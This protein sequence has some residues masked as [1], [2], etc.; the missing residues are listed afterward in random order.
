[1]TKNQK[2][3]VDVIIDSIDKDCFDNILGYDYVKEEMVRWLKFI[4]Y[5]ESG[6]EWTEGFKTDIAFVGPEGTGKGLMAESFAAIYMD[7][8]RLSYPEGKG[9]F[10]LQYR[11][12]KSMSESEIRDGITRMAYQL[13]EKKGECDTVALVISNVDLLTPNQVKDIQDMAHGVSDKVFNV[14]TMEDSD[15]V[16][17][18]E[19]NTFAIKVCKPSESDSKAFLEYLIHEKYK[20]VS[21]ETDMEGLLDI[22]N[23]RS[24]EAVDVLLR[25]CIIYAASRNEDITLDMLIESAL[26]EDTTSFREYSLRDRIEAGVYLAGQVIFSAMHGDVSRGFACLK[27][28]RGDFYCDYK[29]A[30]NGNRDKETLYAMLASIAGYEIRRGKKCKGSEEQINT[31]KKLVLQDL[32]VSGIYGLQYL[33][34]TGSED[35]REKID[36]KASEIMEE[37]YRDTIA[38]LT[39]YKELIWTI[40]E[41]IGT[42]GYILLSEARKLLREFE[43]NR[44]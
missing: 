24:F 21:F 22:F 27:G 2:L 38:M 17:A 20:D 39:P 4:A 44:E 7:I 43:N 37:L 32:T 31:L 3:P 28:S 36:R 8:Y 10:I 34:F 30:Y 26:G 16:S 35:Q 12:S 6:A 1:M 14:V 11:F 23:G 29:V 40:A 41:K 25:H 15:F 42:D 33:E 13:A 18:K 19:L 5:V 9:C